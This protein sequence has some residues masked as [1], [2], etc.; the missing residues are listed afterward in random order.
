MNDK[1]EENAEHDAKFCDCE[2][3]NYGD[4]PLS[5]HE[6]PACA[7][8]GL[9]RPE[10][11]ACVA[12]DP[13]GRTSVCGRSGLLHEFTFTGWEH[14]DGNEANEGRLLTCERCKLV[15]S[16]KKDN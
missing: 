14:A 6:T 12:A 11:I 4:K 13:A 15:R 2:E 7:T 3:F 8:C 10:Y 16:Q 9:W 1:S 5:G